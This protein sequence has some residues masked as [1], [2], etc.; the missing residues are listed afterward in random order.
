MNES[1]KTTT[2]SGDATYSK[3][4]YKFM[5]S[6]KESPPVTGEDA[7]DMDTSING[8]NIEKEE[9]RTSSNNNQS[10]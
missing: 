6:K 2:D 5:A 4:A 1:T 8:S 3:A 9:K 10:I 7:N